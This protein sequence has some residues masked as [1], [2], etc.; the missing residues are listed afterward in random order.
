MMWV[1]IGVV[2]A[3]DVVQLLAVRSCPGSATTNHVSQRT[4]A[5]AC[6]ERDD[7]MV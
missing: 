1:A 5:G 4:S 6:G 3:R 7:M 2:V